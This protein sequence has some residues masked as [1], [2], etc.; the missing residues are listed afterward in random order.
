MDVNLER[1]SPN[2]GSMLGQRRRRWTNID[3]TLSQLHLFVGDL[4]ENVRLML[5]QRRGQWASIKTTLDQP[6]S[7]TLT[8]RGPTL[9]VRI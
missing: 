6:C 5:E 3:P 1:H 2:V 8:V 9:V 7:L 4:R